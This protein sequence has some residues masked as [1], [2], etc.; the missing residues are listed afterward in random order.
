MLIVNIGI[1]LLFCY[2]LAIV[3]LVQL[4]GDTSIANFTWGG[5][6]MLVSLYTLFAF[7]E[8]HTRQLMLTAMMVAWAGRLIRFVYLRYTGNDPRFTT[9]KFQGLKGL[10]INS[11]WVFGQSFMIALMSCPIVL[12]NTYNLPGITFLDCLGALMWIGGYVYETVSD[13]QLSA[14]M[15]DP[16]NKGKVM[17]F[18]LWRYSRHPNYFGEITMWWAVGLITLSVPFGWAAFIAPIAITVSLLFVTGVT[19]IEKTFEDNPEYQD[20]RKKTSMLIPWFSQE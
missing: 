8:F 16:K 5:G 18:G 14:F 20:Y 4:K 19:W 13:Q 3:V 15:S 9:W 1:I 7:S 2:L 11:I 12:V 6:V 10:L 17:R